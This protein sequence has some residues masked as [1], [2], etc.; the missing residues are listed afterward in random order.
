MKEIKN[1]L[2]GPNIDPRAVKELEHL[3]ILGTH[4]HFPLF[5]PSWIRESYSALRDAKMRRQNAS[6][7]SRLV[8]EVYK[9]LARHKSLE[10]QRTVLLALSDKDRNK[11]IQSFLQV[12]EERMLDTDEELH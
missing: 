9:I 8:L 10:R 3:L 5:Y 4:G 12:V 6:S 2:N 11:F 1:Y 7:A